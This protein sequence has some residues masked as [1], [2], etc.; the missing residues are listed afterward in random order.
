MSLN[1][2]LHYYISVLHNQVA[3]APILA[4]A[5]SQNKNNGDQKRE[6]NF[7]GGEQLPKNKWAKD[8]SPSRC[9]LGEIYRKWWEAKAVQKVKKSWQRYLG[10]SITFS[11]SSTRRDS[12]PL[13]AS[14]VVC[15][16]VW[17]PMGFQRGEGGH[18]QAGRW[19]N[20]LQ[21]CRPWRSTGRYLSTQEQHIPSPWDYRK[22]S[23]REWHLG[24][25]LGVE[26]QSKGGG[27][28]SIPGRKCSTSR[29]EW[30]LGQETGSSMWPSIMCKKRKVQ[31]MELQRER[32]ASSGSAE[33]RPWW[34]TGI[35]TIRAIRIIKRF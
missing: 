26:E 28:S 9:N 3:W 32:V 20:T 12:A 22:S 34:G 7:R 35:Y 27:E 11:I 8:M 14:M 15:E 19:Q 10:R 18:R 24:W 29:K 5:N 33:G 13:Q 21:W 4:M 25:A 2:F 1:L 23:Q 30:Y 16:R 17:E 31:G 6:L